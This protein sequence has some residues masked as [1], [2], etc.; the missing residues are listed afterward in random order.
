MSRQTRLAVTLLTAII[1]I[2][3]ALQL[4][5]PDSV[6]MRYLS[7]RRI[8]SALNKHPF[9]T[10]TGQAS[11]FNTSSIAMSAPSAAS[12]KQ[13]PAAEASATDEHGN[14]LGLPAPPAKDDA[15]KLD[16]SNGADSVKLDHLGPLVVN[17]DGTLSRISNWEAMTQQEKKATLRILGKRNQLRT[18]ALKA[19]DGQSQD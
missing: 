6:L 10:F 7:A 17:K 1:A 5:E 12:D 8:A 18:D 11:S 9:T 16:L 14:P 3:L 4:K 19:G 2:L 15:T 13:I